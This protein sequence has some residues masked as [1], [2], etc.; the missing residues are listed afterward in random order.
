MVARQEVAREENFNISKGRTGPGGYSCG[1]RPHDDCQ[2][3]RFAFGHFQFDPSTGD[4]HGPSGLV[5]LSPKALALLGY[6]VLHPAR[7]VSKDELLDALWPDVFVT[8]GVLKV[9]VR[10]IRRA[11]GDDARVPRF[12]ETAHRRGYRFIAPFRDVQVPAGP[13]RHSASTADVCTTREAAT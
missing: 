5:P 12:I 2:N 1:G 6:L 3:S 9:C 7:L 13:S 8:D 10:E 4:L 11:L